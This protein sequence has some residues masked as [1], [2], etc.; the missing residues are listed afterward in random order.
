MV[1]ISRRFSDSEHAGWRALRLPLRTYSR[2]VKMQA[3]EALAQEK[4]GKGWTE[5]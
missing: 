3:A 4:Y 5:L 2:E 1:I